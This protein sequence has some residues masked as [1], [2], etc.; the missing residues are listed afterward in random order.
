MATTLP[1]NKV[2]LTALAILGT[3]SVATI[4]ITLQLALARADEAQTQ[5]KKHCDSLNA[6]PVMQGKIDVVTVKLEMVRE[7]VRK[8]NNKLDEIKDLIRRNTQGP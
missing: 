2:L 3:L 7:E 8:N 4:G 6:H 5:I 1:N